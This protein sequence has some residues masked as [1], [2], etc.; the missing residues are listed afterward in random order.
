M[1]FA[2]VGSLALVAGTAVFADQVD[3]SFEETDNLTGYVSYV[4]IFIFV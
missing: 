2:V 4:N 1:K 3:D